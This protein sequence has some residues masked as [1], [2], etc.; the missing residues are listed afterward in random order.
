MNLATITQTISHGLFLG[1]VA[2]IPLIAHFRKVKVY[3]SFVL[4]AKEGFDIIVR[5][6]PFLVGMLVAIGMFRASGGMDVISHWLQPVLK[7][8]GLPA[9]IL[10]LALIRPFSGSAAN[11]ILAELIHTYGANSFIAK[12]AATISGSTETT[13]Y[14]VALYFGV[15][16]I[17]RT[18]HAI[19]AGLLADITGV[20]ASIWIC[21][22]FFG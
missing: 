22:L 16:S 2:G 12:L 7:W 19:P 15:V 17:Q 14:V 1:L 18:R 5:I 3:D 4:G 9:P 13:F 8:I 21:R 11:G 10:P 20:F 6:I